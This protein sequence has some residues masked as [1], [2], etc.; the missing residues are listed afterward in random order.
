M[1]AIYCITRELCGKQPSLKR[2]DISVLEIKMK[3]WKS[4]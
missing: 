4:K 1:E 2:A 3:E